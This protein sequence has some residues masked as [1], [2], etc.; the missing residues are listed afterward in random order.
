M[1]KKV[2]IQGDL[3]ILCSGL[4]IVDLDGS[5]VCIDFDVVKPPQTNVIVGGRKSESLW[6]RRINLKENC[7]NSSPFIT[8]R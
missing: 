7:S 3:G 8:Y 2:M 5:D 4:A 1:I 6:K